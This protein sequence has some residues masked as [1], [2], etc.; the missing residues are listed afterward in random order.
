M[1]DLRLYLRKKGH[2]H[3][4]GC[5]YNQTEQIN[6][7]KNLTKG[8]KKG[9]EIGFNAGDSAYIF[10]KQGCELTSCDLF[11]HKYTYDA[12][13]YL[14][15]KYNGKFFIVKGDSLKTLPEFKEKYDFIYVDGNHKYKSV[16][17]D[18]KNIIPLCHKDTL[19]IIDDYV[20]NPDYIRYHNIG[21]IQAVAEFD[22]FIVIDNKDFKEGR[23]MIWGKLNCEGLHPQ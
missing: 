22:E 17:Q 6:L 3:Y 2:Y 5:C 8:K 12:C 14:R 13:D 9:L 4:E 7:L 21:V 20:L 10:L 18:L 16:K 1:S 11:L 23:G 19:I 15:D